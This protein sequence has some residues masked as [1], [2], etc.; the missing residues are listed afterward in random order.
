MEWFFPALGET[1]TRAK[2]MCERCTVV[3]EC[4]SF[5]L[6][7]PSEVGIWAGTSDGER[8]RLRASRRDAA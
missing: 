3:D 7:N 1:G 5:A 8:R 4:G 6:S 2:K